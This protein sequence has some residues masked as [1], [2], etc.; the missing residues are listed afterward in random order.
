[1]RFIGVE[2]DRLSGRIAR[3][4]HPGH[5][6]RI[7]NFR[8]TRLPEDRIDAVIG[9]VPFADVELDYGGKRL[10]LHDFFLAKSLD[11]LKPGGVLALVTSHYTLDKQNPGLR[12]HLARA[13]RFPGRDPPAL[14][15]LQAG[16]HQGRH[17]H[18]VPAASAAPGEEPSHADPAWLETAPARH[19]GRR[20]PHQPVLPAASRDG[21]GHLEPQGPALWRRGDYS[22]IGQRRSGR[23]A[24]RRHRA[25][26]PQGVYTARSPSRRTHRQRSLHPPAAPGRHITEGSFFVGDDQDPP[27]GA[28]TARP[29]PSRMARTPL[30]ADGTLMGKRLAALIALR[31]QARRVLQSQNE[32]WPEAH[33]HE[34]RR[35][36]NRVYDRFVAPTAPSTRPPSPTTA[37]GTIIRRMPNL[38]KFRDDPDAMLVMSLEHYD[39][40]TGTAEKGRHH[41]Q[42]RGRPQPA[43][44]R[45]CSSAEE[46]LLVSLDQR[47][48]V[49]LPYIATLY[50]GPRA[51]DHRRAGRPD[52]PGP[53]DAGLADRRRLSLRQRARQAR[54][55]RARRPGLCAQRRGPAP[56]CSPR[57]CC[58]A[59]STPISARPGYRRPTSR[60][61]PRISSASRRPPSRSAT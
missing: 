6:I 27:A 10:A 58:P 55:R 34:A 61:S 11:A 50:N 39:E 53:R 12:E 57:T 46:G 56:R 4:L 48:M 28:S 59:T 5:D 44:H 33:R 19:R 36:L 9:N 42:G 49:D 23:T 2:L 1:M 38:V 22:V 40:A 37:D 17:R 43:R 3:A 24:A 29:C 18:P 52:L 15:R 16:R 21:A 26:C 7:E 35:E 25:R 47:G 41:A 14:R 30:Q 60:P 54:G 8:D 13:G 20:H 32:G 45:P 31:D 51:P